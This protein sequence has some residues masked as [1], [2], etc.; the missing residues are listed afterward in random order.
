MVIMVLALVLVV[1]AC[2]SEKDVQNILN[3]RLKLLLKRLKQAHSRFWGWIV[4]LRLL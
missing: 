2:S 1:S 3:R 4:V